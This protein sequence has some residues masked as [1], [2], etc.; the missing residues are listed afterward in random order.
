[1]SD[2]LSYVGV[3]VGSFV[4][5]CVV[6]QA[7]SI[8]VFGEILEYFDISHDDLINMRHVLRG[9]TVSEPS[10]REVAITVDDV[11]GTLY[12]YTKENPRFIA[13]GPNR[14]ALIISLGLALVNATILITE[15]DAGFAIMQPEETV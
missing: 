1:M 2:V 8:H 14:E 10:G 5:G 13:Q 7:Y 15:G 9:D 3:G 11:D 4:T 12:A 6:A